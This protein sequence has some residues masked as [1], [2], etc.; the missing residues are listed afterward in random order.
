MTESEIPSGKNTRMSQADGAAPTASTATAK[1]Q[2]PGQIFYA[3]ANWKGDGAGAGVIRLPAVGLTIP[4]AGSRKP[5]EPAASANPEEL[6]LAAVAACFV[7]T[8]A[9]FLKKLQVAYPEPAIRLDGSL[10]KDPAG[11]YRMTGAVIH[12]LVPA[13]LLEKDRA[14]VEKTLQ[15][16]EKYCI[17][18]K[19]ARAAMPVRV[20]IEAV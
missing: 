11:G 3:A 4:I 1:E 18:T 10:G 8:W 19:V 16:S 7:N 5:D 12:A 13:S 20:E 15:L 2:E 14:R 6:L 9:I 17:I